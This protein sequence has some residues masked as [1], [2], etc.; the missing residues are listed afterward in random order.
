M[1]RAE[2]LGDVD[3]GQAERRYK[4]AVEHGILKVMSKMGISTLQSYR[5][6]QIF[7]A[8]GLGDELLEKWFPDTPSQIGGVGL[9]AIADDA[10]A[11]HAAAHSPRTLDVLEPGGRYAWRRDGETHLWN[12][13]TIGTLQHAV[14]SGSF[15]TFQKFSAIAGSRARPSRPA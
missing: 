1:D 11:R 8:I 12:P 2:G 3:P 13:K 10:I 7:E 4:R 5:G 6:A 9:D 14:R 15:A